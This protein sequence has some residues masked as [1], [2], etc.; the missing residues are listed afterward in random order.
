MRKR[1]RRSALAALLICSSLPLAQTLKLSAVER[2]APRIDLA[3]ELSSITKSLAAAKELRHAIL[4]NASVEGQ[5][6]ALFATSAFQR[7]VKVIERWHAIEEVLAT[8]SFVYQ[9]DKVSKKRRRGKIK[10]KLMYNNMI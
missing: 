10:A 2:F 9:S 7:L 3:A 1:S 6:D 5:S 4:V 8:T